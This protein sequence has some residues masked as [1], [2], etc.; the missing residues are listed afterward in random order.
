MR[1]NKIPLTLINLNYLTARFTTKSIQ[2]SLNKIARFKYV[3]LYEIRYY[4]GMCLRHL[5]CVSCFE[6][7]NPLKYIFL[8]SLS[9]NVWVVWVFPY[10]YEIRFLVILNSSK[11]FWFKETGIIKQYPPIS[12]NPIDH[13]YCHHMSAA[14]IF[15]VCR[16]WLKVTATTKFNDQ[17]KVYNAQGEVIMQ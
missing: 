1:L 5:I 9:Y 11:F 8:T 14:Y 10:I 13:G 6:V 3:Y 2:R 4:V 16:C 17:M 7:F 12:V 15:Y